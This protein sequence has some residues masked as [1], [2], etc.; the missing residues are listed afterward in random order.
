MKVRLIDL[1]PGK[2]FRFGNTVGFKSEY[3]AGGAVEAFIVGSG[4]MF[5]GGTSGALK[6]RELMVEPIELKDIIKN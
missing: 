5:W 3:M 6:Q 1:E 2:L 4:E